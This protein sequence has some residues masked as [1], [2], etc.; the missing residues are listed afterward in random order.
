MF[1]VL[2]AAAL[3]AG[4]RG[5]AWEQV[6]DVQAARIACAGLRASEHFG[7]VEEQATSRM[8]PDVC[9]LALAGLDSLCLQAVYE[10]SVDPSICDHIYL[11]ETA[12]DCRE[13]FALP[14]SRRRWRED[15]QPPTAEQVAGCAAE[16]A[17]QE[18]AFRDA[19]AAE[20]QSFFTLC[21]VLGAPDWVTGGEMTVFIYDLSDGGEIRL[22]FETPDWLSSAYLITTDGEQIDL[23]A[24]R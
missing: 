24:E 21:R 23:L 18:P 20:D 8:N 5:P 15:R 1:A 9:H 12:A 6:P 2:I 14:E 13:W 4:C 7:C 3:L 10:A 19:L 16:T 17:R 11:K 22:G